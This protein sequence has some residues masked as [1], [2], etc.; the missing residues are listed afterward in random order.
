MATRGAAADRAR[1]LEE[2]AQAAATKEC[3]LPLC[4]H[5]RSRLT[6]ARNCSI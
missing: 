2:R 3:V 5:L 4:P 6:V 1:G